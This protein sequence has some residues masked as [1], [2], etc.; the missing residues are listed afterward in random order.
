MAPICFIRPSESKI[1]VSGPN[2]PLR[3]VEQSHTL[4]E[5]CRWNRGAGLQTDPYL[6][7]GGAVERVHPQILALRVEQVLPVTREAELAAVRFL[8][9]GLFPGG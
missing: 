7:P 4:D 6:F 5:G 8:Y 2:S 3:E 9:G 1:D